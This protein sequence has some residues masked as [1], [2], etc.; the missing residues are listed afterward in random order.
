ME[1]DKIENAVLLIKLINDL[2]LN[3]VIKQI[4]EIKKIHNE[5]KDIADTI[6]IT[7]TICEKLKGCSKN[8]FC[9]L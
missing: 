8:Y 5:L 1:V 2:D 7:K 4:E 9:C 6:K 3:T